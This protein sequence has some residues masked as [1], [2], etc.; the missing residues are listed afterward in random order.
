MWDALTWQGK[1]L[2][3]GAVAM[4][5]L[6]FLFL[7][8]R[9]NGSSPAR[10]L[11]AQPTIAAITVIPPTQG[12]ATATAPPQPTAAAPTGTVAPQATATAQATAPPASATPQPAAS[13]PAPLPP[14]AA[15]QP[16]EAPTPRPPGC[17]AQVSVSNASPAAGTSVTISGKLT[18]AGAGV[19]NAQMSAIATSQGGRQSGCGALTDATGAGACQ[20]VIPAA[21]TGANSVNACFSYQGQVTCAQTSFT[22]H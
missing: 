20:V 5:L 9:S 2:A 17:E 1:L 11:A 8:G 16:T 10:S 15:P 22:A 18:C 14:T 21:A 7:S 4:A 6:L 13:T 3:I 19:P 12:P